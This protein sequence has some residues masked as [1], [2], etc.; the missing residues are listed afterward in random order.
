MRRFLPLLLAAA[1]L[2]ALPTTA[3]AV[4][5]GVESNAE[6]VNSNRTYAQRT[7][8]IARMHAQGARLVRIN[9]GWNELAAG[10]GGQSPTTLRNHGAACYDWSVFDQVVQLATDRDMQVLVSISRAP[11]WLHGSSNPS[12]LGATSQQWQRTVV[13]Y[14]AVMFA[15]ARRYRAGSELG[16]VRLWTVWNE[17]NSNTYFAPLVT[18]SQ[19]LLGPARYAQLL[20]RSAVALKSANSFALVAAGPTGPTGGRYGIKPITYVARVQTVLPRYLPGVGSAERRWI[21]AWAHNPYPGT[22]IAPSRGTIRSPAVGMT[23]VADLLRQLDRSPITRGRP[24]WATEFGYQTNPPDRLLGISPP[25]QGRYLAESFDWLARTGRIPIAVWYGFV[26]GDL[27]DD[28]Q[29][30]THFASGQRKVSYFWYQRPISV[31]VDRIRRGSSVRVWARSMVNPR[32]TRIA[33]STNGRTWR[34]LPLRGRRADRSQV[35]SV[36]LSTTTWF[37]TWDGRRGPARVVR[38]TGRSRQL[39]RFPDV[40][41]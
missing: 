31:P 35:Q 16:H 20:A 5:Y 27:P 2:L 26:D 6:L 30:G 40:Q 17:P 28:W 41:A 32:A 29:S 34:L 15:A 25:L 11:T 21:D 9:V 12:W 19:Q 7:Q 3:G 37:A 39:V 36:R 10:C 38:V 4:T 8:T 33:W 24:I 13:H 14:E 22:N 18:R 1:S 23:N